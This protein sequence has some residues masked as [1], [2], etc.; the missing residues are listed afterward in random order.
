MSWLHL[1]YSF[2]YNVRIVFFFLRKIA[3]INR[4]RTL[5]ECEY[6]YF[7]SF[8]RL[9]KNQNVYSSSSIKNSS[10]FSWWWFSAVINWLSAVILKVYVFRGFFALGGV[11]QNPSFRSIICSNFLLIGVLDISKVVWILKKRRVA[12]YLGHDAIGIKIHK[13]SFLCEH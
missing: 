4:M 2:E 3:N 7:F 6:Y 8:F 10:L 13:T 11:W 5:I 9:E 12:S 1:P